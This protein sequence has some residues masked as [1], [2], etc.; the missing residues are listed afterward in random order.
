[1][2]AE[3][4]PAPQISASLPGEL[5]GI[6]AYFNPAGYKN[7]L[8]NLRM[9]AERV[10]SQGVKLM[11]VEL[12]FGRSPFEV[13]EELCDV[14]ERRRSDAVLWQKERLMNIGVDLLPSACDKVALLDGDIL[15]E[16]DD[17]VEETATLLE[18]YCV[19][20]PFDTAYW[21]AKGML[22]A[23][24][25]DVGLGNREGQSLPS[26]AYAMSHTADRREAFAHYHKNGHLGFAW[27]VRRWL[28]KKHRLYD[29]Q[30]LG[31]GDFDFGH[32]IYGDE[33]YWNGR[34]WMV[35]RVSPKLLADIVKWSTALYHDVHGSVSYV[36]GRVL[37]L[38]HGDQKDRQ[39]CDRLDI[40]KICDFDPEVDLV[41][42]E[43]DA[44]IWGSEKPQLHKWA[45]EYF[46]SRKEE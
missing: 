19:V 13:P 26:M 40:L 46:H 44:W 27:A 32:A 6:T 21:L 16:N 10:R 12:A 28:L 42:N 14:L 15:F 20:Q 29:R 36:P 33:D 35:H 43:D 30:I 24:T 25:D 45:Q 5:W 11:V 2:P 4:L 1:M 37:H 31:S 39:Y 22:T 3:E 41:K 23:P 18:S 7:K 34:S 17:W 38:W 8:Q 9:F